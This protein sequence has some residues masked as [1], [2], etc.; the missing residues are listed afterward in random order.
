MMGWGIAIKFFYLIEHNN[1]QCQKYYDN[2]SPQ[3]KVREFYKNGGK[4]VNFDIAS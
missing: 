1:E 4:G 3:D 2:L